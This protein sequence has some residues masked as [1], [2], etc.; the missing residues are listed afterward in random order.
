MS[1]AIHILQLIV[2][3]IPWYLRKELLIDWVDSLLSPLQTI[4]DKLVNLSN[5]IRYRTAFNG[6]SILLKH[7]LNDKFDPIDRG[8]YISDGNIMPAVYHFFSPETN[9]VQAYT[10][11]AAETNLSGQVFTFFMSELE[12][13]YYE[14]VVNVPISLGILTTDALLNGIIKYYKLAGKRYIINLY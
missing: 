8:I 1:Y 3:L 4:N 10:W 11:N 9:P 6:Q 12:T 13:D 7:V 14:F 2:G 5:E